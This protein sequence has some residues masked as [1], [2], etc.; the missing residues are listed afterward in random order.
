MSVFKGTREAEGEEDSGLIQPAEVFAPKSLVLVSRLD[1]P[2]IFRVKS[3][4]LLFVMHGDVQIVYVPEEFSQ[5]LN[6]KTSLNH[7]EY[8]DKDKQN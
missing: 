1:Y 3:T 5:A 2:E 6:F 7:H 8:L 4:Y